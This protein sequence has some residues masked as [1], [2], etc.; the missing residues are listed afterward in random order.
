MA[1]LKSKDE[2][3]G[4]LNEKMLAELIDHQERVK[5]LIQSRITDITF[6]LHCLDIKKFKFDYT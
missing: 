6:R 2:I 1:K 5:G 3:E 4:L